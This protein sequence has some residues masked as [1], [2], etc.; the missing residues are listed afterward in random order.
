M[1]LV[2]TASS[3]EE[4]QT[5][6]EKQESYR[7]IG[8]QA[9][10]AGDS[11]SLRIQGSAPPTYT[12][13]ELFDP[14]RIVLDIADA[15][16][17]ESVNLPQKMTDGPVTSV[18]GMVLDDKKPVVGRLEIFLAE[19]RVYSV[20]R[21]ANDII[22]SFQ[23]K[24]VVEKN[25]K[26]SDA[27]EQIISK[28]MV[29]NQ[30]TAVQESAE[31]DVSSEE[32]AVISEETAVVEEK[33]EEPTPEELPPAKSKSAATVQNFSLAGYTKQ[34][35]SIDFYKIDLHNV[36]RLF[37]EI[38]GQNIII[39]E[40]VAGEITLAL[41][42]VPWD[43][44]LDIIMSLKG[45]QK[46]ERHG[47]LIIAPKSMEFNMPARPAD[48]LSVTP[49]V[50]VASDT[51]KADADSLSVKNEQLLTPEMI[52][53]QRLMFEAAAME[54]AEDFDEA[55]MLYEAA[56]AK[57]P[58]NGKLARQLASLYLVYK[59]MNA[60]AVHYAEA[61]LRI[62][63][64]DR[65]A[66]LYA[67]IGMASMKRNDMAGE[68]FSKAVEEGDDMSPPPAEALASY[69]AFNEEA[70][71]YMGALLLL[72]R[73]NELYGENMDTMIAKARIYDKEGSRAKAAAEYRAIL[74][75][76]YDLPDDLKR[77]I[78]GRIA[79]ETKE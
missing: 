31:K 36:F 79:M 2:V 42:N 52:A 43:F 40:G 55:I 17:A 21:Q 8:I 75:S 71:D 76:G 32:T 57:W 9:D 68:Y 16:F 33:A 37:G 69:A 25:A 22:V 11:F 10:Q 66:A 65:L 45:L 29:A 5:A 38:S 12:I 50:T 59:G 77:Y 64:N 73:H 4:E 72:N 26:K 30:P 63:E 23:E 47:T 51:T 54:K 6:A 56:F 28:Q 34:P 19:D 53:A 3:A 7:L 41:D 1:L 48:N 44:A 61:A 20:E 35:I 27:V 70:G 46:I 62:D 60:K 15:S 18:N 24:I 49:K 74:L 39:T 14:L 58:E 67:A 13:Y 78:R